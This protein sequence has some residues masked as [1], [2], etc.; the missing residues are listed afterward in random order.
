MEAHEIKQERRELMRDLLKIIVLR[1]IASQPKHGYGMIMAIRRAFGIYLG[2]STMYPLL[3]RLEKKGYVK[4]EWDMTNEKPRKVY[5]LTR[6]GERVLRVQEEIL[7]D[8]G[9]HARELLPE[10]QLHAGTHT[11]HKRLNAS[12]YRGLSTRFQRESTT[13]K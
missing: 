9:D 5:T 13:N 3:R 8:V 2:P 1:E 7:R 12:S 4:S 10:V 11:K 6:E